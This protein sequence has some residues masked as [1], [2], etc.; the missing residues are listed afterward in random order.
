[1]NGPLLGQFTALLLKKLN[2]LLELMPDWSA[3]LLGEFQTKR[4]LLS[5][6]RMEAGRL[7]LIFKI[8]LKTLK[9]S[10]R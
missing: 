9:Q 8:I 7:L 2:H 10:M 1:M 5:A 3:S 4:K 6:H